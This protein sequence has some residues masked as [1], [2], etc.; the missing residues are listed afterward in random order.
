MRQRLAVRQDVCGLRRIQANEPTTEADYRRDLA[1][2]VHERAWAL[3]AKGVRLHL[4]ADTLPAT[5]WAGGKR[6]TRVRRSGM[7][8]GHQASPWHKQEYTQQHRKGRSK[9]YA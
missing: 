1:E 2:S 8:V 7:L 9:F 3:H 4:C 5:F 6:Q